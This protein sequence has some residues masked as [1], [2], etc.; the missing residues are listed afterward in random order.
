[1]GKNVL[2]NLRL[3]IFV[4]AGLAFTVLMLYMIGSSRNIF[5]SNFEISARFRNVNGLME[6]NNVRLA[7][8][9]VGTVKRIDMISDTTVEVVMIIEKRMRR[10][11]M[12]NAIA[13]VGTD[14]LMG[15][16]LVNINAGTEPSLPISKG[17]ILSSR[18]PIESDEMLR[19]MNT[20]NINLARITYEMKSVTEKL[21]RSK[22]L[23]SLLQDTAISEDIRHSLSNIRATT[24]RLQLATATT[25]EILE[26]IKK[27][28]GTLAMLISD[29]LLA[30]QTRQSLSTLNR[31]LNNAESI[32]INLHSLSANLIDPNNT[33]HLLSSDSAFQNKVRLILGHIDE[34]AI[35]ARE[36]L[37]ALRKSFLL[38]RAFKKAK[39]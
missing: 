25:H 18:R 3:G 14:G 21:N 5:S 17:D 35:A 38:R 19:T 10:F 39:P 28:E 26:G 11:I 24:T 4:F 8:I 7:G 16:K 30:S 33:I 22:S 29:T 34:T 12:K 36:D 15:S 37:I 1:M 27:G 13:S 9:N 31:T 32:S 6:G 2:N 20:T 23:W